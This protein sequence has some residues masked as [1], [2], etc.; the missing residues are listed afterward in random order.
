[1]GKG[2]LRALAEQFGVSA[3]W[4]FKVSSAKRQTGTWL[5]TPQRRATSRIDGERVRRLIE[6]KPD[7]LL[8]ELQSEMLRGGQ[9]ISLA[10]MAR[11]VKGLGLVLKKSRST[12]PSGTRNPTVRSAKSS[13]ASL[14]RSRRKT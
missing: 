10:H 1:M 4:A 7:I 9:P 11:V 2:S 3:G 13:L 5:R 8:R 12:P 14:R 6:K